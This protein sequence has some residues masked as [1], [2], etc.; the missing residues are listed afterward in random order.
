M[1]EIEKI[2]VTEETQDGAQNDQNNQSDQNNSQKKDKVFDL[3]SISENELME[4]F[5]S[6][7]SSIKAELLRLQSD[8]LS[9]YITESDFKNLRL[10]L[11]E[12]F[13]TNQQGSITLKMLKLLFVIYLNKDDAYKHINQL[14]YKNTTND[15]VIGIK[16]DC[17]INLYLENKKLPRVEQFKSGHL[18]GFLPRNN[19]LFPLDCSI[20]NS[21][22]SN[23]FEVINRFIR[24][25]QS[26]TNV[27]N[28]EQ[29]LLNNLIITFNKRN[30]EIILEYFNRL[31]KPT[32]S[33][34][35]QEIEEEEIENLYNYN[36]YIEK[37]NHKN[38]LLRLNE[39]EI[40]IQDASMQDT[41]TSMQDTNASMQDTNTQD[42]NTQDTNTDASTQD[43]QDIQ[44]ELSRYYIPD[45]TI[46]LS[47][48]HTLLNKYGEFDFKFL[49]SPLVKRNNFS[50]T[51]P[52]EVITRTK[53]KIIQ[54]E[55][56]NLNEYEKMVS[57]LKYT[58]PNCNTKVL[59]NVND[60]ATEV[61]HVCDVATQKKTKINQS[62][63][64]PQIQTP[65]IMYKCE[66]CTNYNEVLQNNKEEKY[67]KE[68]Y[69]YSFEENIEPG[70]Y[71]TDI[72]KFY[73]P[74]NILINKNKR[75]LMY[76]LLGIKKLK[77]KYI[78]NKIIKTDED[79]KKILEN[80]NIATA[81]KTQFRIMK[82]MKESQKIQ[83]HK[84][85]NILFS[86]RQYYKN[87]LG[88]EINNSGM[89][90]QITSL[91]SILARNLFHEN[92][93]AISIMGV[94]SISKTFP[95]NMILSMTDLNYKYISDAGRMTSAGMT[96]GINTAANI[97]G[98]TTRKFEQGVISNNGAV[99]FDEAQSI[100]L[101]KDIQAIIKSIPQDEY[102]ISIVGGSSVDFN[103]TPIFLSNFNEFM[104]E[105]EKR[106][107]DAYVL[108]YKSIY[109]FENERKLKTNQDII[110]YVSKINLYQ[111][112]EFYYDTMGDEILANIV[113]AVRKQFESERIDWK[114]GS[115]IEATNRILFDT[116]VHRKNYQIEV[117]LTEGLL[118]EENTKDINLTEN[119]PIQ[120]TN[121]EIL[122]YVYNQ[123]DVNKITKI[124]I[125]N[126]SKNP[127]ERVM[128]LQKLNKSIYKFLTKE[129]LGKNISKYYIQNVD[130]FDKKIRELVIKTI[131]I[132]QLI[133]DIDSTEI[134][135]NTKRLANQLLLKCKR[136]LTQEEYDWDINVT[137]IKI[138]PKLNSDF[139]I[140][141][142][143]NKTELYYEQK[144]QKDIESLEKS[145]ESKYGLTKKENDH[146][147][148]ESTIKID[149]EIFQDITDI[150]KDTKNKDTKNTT[151]INNISKISIDKIDDM[152]R[153]F[154]LKQICRRL[155]F[156]SENEQEMLEFV[157]KNR[158][159]GRIYEA[160]KGVYKI[161]RN[162]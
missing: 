158:K 94:G 20:L 9:S 113:F 162:Q 119:M 131:K 53:I 59:L 124:N 69:V 128:Q 91:I 109:K 118:K 26:N 127:I 6:N 154:D 102:N 12:N 51:T 106:I 152:D 5:S 155:N 14:I 112:I 65:V 136:G 63:I 145:I 85:W 42:T 129:R 93:L 141:L 4:Y 46:K 66:V 35:T 98:I 116:V 54:K 100:F 34:T 78:E 89:F 33:D 3:E 36:E 47:N 87:R 121:E 37:Y 43:E 117:D 57:K 142:E 125:K 41:N 73:E 108:K 74:M 150:N 68:V 58:C 30:K 15:I 7:S 67:I 44:D 32:K 147:L 104:M 10:F 149:D 27:I 123:T 88:M 140:D 38:E 61:V 77:N 19:Y 114:T 50:L 71:I 160:R 90:A 28:K 82:Q 135:E 143:D 62:G 84:I 18:K 40:N 161:D 137:E 105:Y 144:R 56:M 31:K 79:I 49:L 122:K 126:E 115:Q 29:N 23:M 138:Y 11:I 64:Y 146:S 21:G 2:K 130:N 153:E 60:L 76:F 159:N 16:R 107:V 95:C 22:R 1:V 55:F 120:Q 134:S 96:G 8:L 80:K 13:K 45:E 48:I 70:Y 99:T 86:I 139:L 97:N 110:K 24:Q 101:N 148:K 72:V 151:D 132:L 111:N 25:Y 156:E 39:L 75:Q 81:S 103:C 133:E 157:K 83:A 52:E 92:K 17:Y